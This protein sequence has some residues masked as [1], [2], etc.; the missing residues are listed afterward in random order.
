MLHKNDFILEYKLPLVAKIF[1]TLLGL[2]TLFFIV[3]G[4]A[5]PIL[6]YFH[7]FEAAGTLYSLL[8][9]S[10]MQDALHSFWIMG[11]QTAICGRCFGAYTGFLISVAGA[12]LGYRFGWKMFLAFAII[13]FGEKLL[14]LSGFVANNIIRYI[15]GCFL[16]CFLFI[17]IIV[18]V[19]VFRKEEKD[20]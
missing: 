2:Y 12:I 8:S 5:A 6:A 19:R 10:C 3:G 14:E 4:L 13:G 9:A 18:L 11:Y 1:L 16:G 17:I 20:V 7:K 15:S